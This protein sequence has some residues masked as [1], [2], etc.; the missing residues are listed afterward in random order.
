M[1]SGSWPQLAQSMDPKADGE[2]RA[3]IEDA[4]AYGGAGQAKRRHLQFP[5]HAFAQSFG[6]AL[7][8]L[9]MQ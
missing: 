5:Q 1:Q 9:Q 4:F 6:I 2:L 3:S 7:A 8:R